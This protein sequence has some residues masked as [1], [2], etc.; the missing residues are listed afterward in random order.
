MNEQSHILCIGAALW[1][2]IGR[3]PAPMRIGSDVAGRIARIPGGVALNIAMALVRAGARPDL[4]AAV[5][6]DAAGDALVADMAAYGVSVQHLYRAPDLPT[7]T[8]MAIEGAGGLIAAIADVHSL[9]MAGAKVLAPL[10]DGR[11]ASDA[12]PWH[13]MIALDGNLTVALLAEIGS[14][15]ALAQA[16]LR[17][18][19]A[20]P[21]KG[22]RVLPLLKRPGTVFYVNLEEA[23]LLCGTEFDGSAAAAR[24]LL[25]RGARRVLVT[26]G[27]RDTTDACADAV[28]TQAPPQV[29]AA[30]VT[31]AGDTFMAAHMA[32][33]AQG[34]A[35]EDALRHALK[36]AA[37]YVAGGPEH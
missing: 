17:V 10:R 14:A 32:A 1:D 6:Q 21:G 36:V 37:N 3:T 4:L 35:R 12:A 15:P 31:G 22:E 16:D 8:Y 29:Q 30:R 28:L 11:L 7:D 5:G 13:G 23:G 25:A 24:G 19:P 26:D 33:E 34:M 20:S 2:I 27:A 18:A 9:E